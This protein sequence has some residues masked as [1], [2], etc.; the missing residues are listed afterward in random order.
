MGRVAEGFA[1]LQSGA[2]ADEWPDL[3]AECT[4]IGRTMPLSSGA[5]NAP[6]GTRPTPEYRYRSAAEYKR[7]QA[8]G[9]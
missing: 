2:L 7:A 8:A 5:T 9:F 3:D 1:A 6:D 4:R